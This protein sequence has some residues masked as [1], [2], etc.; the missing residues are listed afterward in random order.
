MTN[1][2]ISD[3]LTLVHSDIRG[4]VYEEALRMQNAGKK[5]LKLNTGN[6]AA[7][8]FAMP[9]SVKEALTRGMDGAVAYCDLRGMPES[10]RAILSYHTGKGIKDL[11]MDDIFITNGVSEGVQMVCLSYL[12]YGD[13][14]LL[15]SP[16]YSLWENCTHLAGAKPVFYQCREENQWMPD[17]EDIRSKVTAKTR[18]ILI[19]SPNNPTGAVYSKEVM[20]EIIA[21]AREHDLAIFSD[22]IYDRLVMDGLKAISPASLAP[23]LLTVTF[24]GL[25]KSHIVCGFRCG[26]M[27]FS[28]PKEKRLPLE[29]AVTKLC[30]MRLCSNALAQLVVPAA[31]EDPESTR[32][33]LVPGGRL[34]EQRETTCSVLEKIEGISFVKNRAAFYLFPKLDKERFGIHNDQQFALDLLHAK[35]LLIIPS[36]GFGW[37]GNDHFRIVMLPEKEVLRSAMEDLGDFL[38]DYKQK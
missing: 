27:V 20:E 36:S 31:L 38:S 13:E 32:E 29:E 24:N 35:N 34:Y 18:A 9:E 1:S 14:I 37:K 3:K 6:P 2:G 19:I 28:G 23:D 33:M 21:I 22:E 5:V 17:P 4:P 25:S 30:S 15:P 16:N 8:G 26:W 7:F 10:R 11:E 12:S